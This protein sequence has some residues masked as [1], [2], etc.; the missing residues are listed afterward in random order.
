MSQQLLL[1]SC[2]RWIVLLPSM[3]FASLLSRV[4]RSASARSCRRIR[5]WDIR[6]RSSRRRSGIVLRT[7]SSAS[8]KKKIRSLLCW[9]YSRRN[10]LFI[11]FGLGSSFDSV[12][13][14]S[15][16]SGNTRAHGHSLRVEGRLSSEILG[17]SLL[18]EKPWNQVSGGAGSL[19]LRDIFEGAPELVT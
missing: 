10:C 7:P 17:L 5:M 19:H 6:M 12:L 16:T 14:F 2:R 15:V 11:S 4:E 13:L 8:F 1:L 18:W 3:I 9:S